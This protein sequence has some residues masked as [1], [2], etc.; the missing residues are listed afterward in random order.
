MLKAIQAEDVIRHNHGY[1][2]PLTTLNTKTFS[3]WTDSTQRKSFTVPKNY[4]PS[5]CPPSETGYWA[6]WTSAPILCRFLTPPAPP[7][8]FFSFLFLIILSKGKTSAWFKMH[9]LHCYQ[10]DQAV[11]RFL[12]QKGLNKSSR[13]TVF[14]VLSIPPEPV[15]FHF[16][17]LYTFYNC[18]TASENT[19]RQVISEPTVPWKELNV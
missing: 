10:T 14:W 5:E 12:R 6:R 7:L 3:L 2:N 17:N 18:N 9:C 8:F 13:V 4:S 15:K 16:E 19:D 1:Q 11:P